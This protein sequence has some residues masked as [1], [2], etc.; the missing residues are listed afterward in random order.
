MTMK[1]QFQHVG[2]ICGAL[3]LYLVGSENAT[4]PVDSET[5]TSCENRIGFS[6]DCVT[7]TLATT[8]ETTGAWVSQLVDFN[9][10]KCRSLDT[11]GTCD[12]SQGDILHVRTDF[13]LA[14]GSIKREPLLAVN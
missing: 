1:E 11:S 4:G 13:A 6:R 5:Y 3:W 9:T 12:Q 7:E 2:V 14:A 10:L 8:A